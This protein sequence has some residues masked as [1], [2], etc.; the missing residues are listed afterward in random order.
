MNRIKELRKE[1]GWKQSELGKLLNVQEAAISK[2]ESEK[3]PLTNDTL[4]RLSQIF[5][6][7][8]DYILSISDI[9]ETSK[10]QEE[11]DEKK[12]LEIYRNLSSSSKDKVIERA[13]TLLELEQQTT[14][15]KD[16]G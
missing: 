4:I 14:N 7:S 2:Y 9:K 8:V 3:I 6:V 1:R 10:S 13:E 5:N 15:N 16:V 11:I 12:L